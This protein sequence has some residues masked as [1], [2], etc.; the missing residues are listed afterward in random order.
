MSVVHFVAE[1]WWID[2]FGDNKPALRLNG[3]AENYYL[4]KETKASVNL[5]HEI[6]PIFSRL[7][8]YSVLLDEKGNSYIERLKKLLKN[9]DACGIVH[10]WEAEQNQEELLHFDLLISK[11]AYD[12]LWKR[13]TNPLPNCIISI[14]VPEEALRAS[15]FCTVISVSI[16]LKYTN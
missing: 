11:Q 13:T 6:D 16:S 3:K 8:I 1:E 2:V 4:G 9:N 15:E 14:S 7:E 5:F 12:E 10:L